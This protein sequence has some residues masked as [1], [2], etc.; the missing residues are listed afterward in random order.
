MFLP[1]LQA[2]GNLKVIK[3]TLYPLTMLHS[4]HCI[5]ATGRIGLVRERG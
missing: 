1:E 4:S 5:F 3:D 2:V